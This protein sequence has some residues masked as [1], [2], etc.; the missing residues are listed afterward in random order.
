MGTYV[1]ETLA[2]YEAPLEEEDARFAQSARN[3]DHWPW[4][5]SR[6][7]CRGQGKGSSF[8]SYG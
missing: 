5:Y 6:R 2:Q 3:R 8:C 1:T 7:K 4:D